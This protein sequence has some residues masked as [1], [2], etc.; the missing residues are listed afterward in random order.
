VYFSGKERRRGHGIG[1]TRPGTNEAPSGPGTRCQRSF[2]KK[3]KREMEA[4]CIPYISMF[5]F[6]LH[7]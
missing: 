1:E 3:G 4:M 7:I 5:V 6:S 2:L